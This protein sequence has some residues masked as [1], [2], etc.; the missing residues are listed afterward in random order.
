MNLNGYMDFYLKKNLL[1]K[2]RQSGREKNE[3]S[4]REVWKAGTWYDGKDR[5]VLGLTAHVLGIYC[6]PG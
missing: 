4:G 3:N 2:E 6:L 5:G 1:T